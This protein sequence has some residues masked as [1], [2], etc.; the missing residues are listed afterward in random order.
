MLGIRT[1]TVSSE[2]DN[3]HNDD[4]NDKMWMNEYDIK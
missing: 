4:K 3:E 1:M 2:N